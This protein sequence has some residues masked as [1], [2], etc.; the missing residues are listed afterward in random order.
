MK[1]TQKLI[2]EIRKLNQ[3]LD[4]VS[5]QSKFMVYSANPIK[6]AWFNFIGGL[7]HSLG[8]LFGTA[9]VAGTIV[10][11]LSQIDFIIPVSRFFESVFT[12]IRW[13]Q[14]LPTTTPSP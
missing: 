14:V 12:Q 4:R 10:Y 1:S 7:F 3:H 2:L 8:S 11:L 13:E 9:V 6:F 5:L